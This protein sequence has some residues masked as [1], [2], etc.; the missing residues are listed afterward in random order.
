MKP[1]FPQRIDLRA[2]RERVKAR[3][4]QRRLWRNPKIRADFRK[5]YGR[6]VT[7]AGWFHDG[8]HRTVMAAM[9]HVFLGPK[10]CP[11]P[12]ECGFGCSAWNGC[13][14]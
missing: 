6:R 13:R 7:F 2:W 12:C 11:W 8:N 3:W 14:Q 9:R 5:D 10:V 1:T 4:A